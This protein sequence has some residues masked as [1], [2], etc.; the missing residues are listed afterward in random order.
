[1]CGIRTNKLPVAPYSIGFVYILPKS[2]AIIIYAIVFHQVR[3]S[4]K[5]VKSRNVTNITTACITLT[6]V[7]K[8]LIVMRNML[9][10]LNILVCGGAPYLILML[11]DFIPN[12]NPPKELYFISVN[13][14]VSATAMMAIVTFFKDKRLRNRAYAWFVQSNSNAR[15]LSVFE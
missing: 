8:N 11:W 13:S 7:K 2:I 9:V 15:S 5:R 3:L 10:I 4:S 12:G 14:L 1:M 6:F